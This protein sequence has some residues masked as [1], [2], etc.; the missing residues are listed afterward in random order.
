M[1][2][3]QIARWALERREARLP[4]ELM[5]RARLHVADSFAIALAASAGNS[6]SNE[7]RHALRM[8]SRGGDCSVIGSADRQAP[9]AAAFENAARIH[10]LDFDDIHDQ[11]R[12]HPTTVSLAAA[13]AAAGLRPASMETITNAVA[14][15]DELMCRL[16]VV[17]APR[18]TGPGADWFLTQLFGYF[19]ASLASALVLDLDEHRIASALGLAY[20]QAAGSKEAGFGVG[21][22]ARAIY[23][24]FAAQGGMTA[25]LLALAGV[26][27]PPAAFEG[28]AGLFRL[29]L[30][31]DPEQASSALLARPGWQFEATCIKPWPCCRFS[32]P[33]VAAALRAHQALEGAP[34]RRIV[35]AVNAT[36]AKLCHPLE[37]RR[38]PATLQDAKYSIPFMIAF[39]LV[40]GRVDL[41]N[42]HEAAL[43]DPAV[44]AMAQR[45][46]IEETLSDTT[47]L[48]AAQIV[49]ST[50]TRTECFEPD[51]PMTLTQAQTR[52]KFLTCT[53]SLG[54]ERA[55]QLWATLLA[56]D[57]DLEACLQAIA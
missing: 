47:G 24:A 32:H 38:V 16:G 41:D 36:A 14:I 27:G 35:A 11:A 29:Y 18:G 20:M 6:M 13:V 33:Y 37:G 3:R 19:G 54:S 12:L 7:V 40:K 8:G 44:L 45:V 48:P 53:H 52:E 25:T 17:C 46:E 22:T 55:G 4:P 28:L 51:R 31:I 50:D 9:A 34:V 43:K 1:L 42:L 21:S 2:S 56:A 39:A 30:T 15:A 49:V 5:V 57:S 10:L 26:A 23:P